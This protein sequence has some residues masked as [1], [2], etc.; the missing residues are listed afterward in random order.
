MS[1]RDGLVLR[2]RYINREWSWL[3]FNERV[4]E[5]AEDGHNPLLERVK[6][7]AIFAGN[8]DEFYMKRVA[9]L[10]NV[11]DEG[12]NRTDSFGYLPQE[13]CQGIETITDRLRTRHYSVFRNLL[14]NDLA[15]EGIRLLD[16]IDTG[17]RESRRGA[18]LLRLDGVP[19]GDTDG[20]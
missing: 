16:T 9:A 20:G 13:A 19:F 18:D 15:A 4:L 6:F 12:S 11:I 10:C 3:A 14:R 1:T 8:L 7:V 2:D 5:E 17:H